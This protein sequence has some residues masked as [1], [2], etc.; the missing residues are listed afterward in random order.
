VHD[1]RAAR[2]PASAGAAPGCGR[3]CG[4]RRGPRWGGAHP[5][6]PLGHA[7]P[8]AR[9]TPTRS[10]RHRCS[11]G[12]PGRSSEAGRRERGFDGAGF[13]RIHR[14]PWP[15]ARSRQG[16]CARRV[17]RLAGGG[18]FPDAMQSIAVAR[19]RIA[20]VP[21]WDFPRA[22]VGAQVFPGNDCPGEAPADRHPPGP[23][24][25][26]VRLPDGVGQAGPR[27]ELPRIRKLAIPRPGP[28]STS[29]PP[30]TRK[31]QAIGKDKAGRWQYRYHPRFR[32]RQEQ[33]KFQKLVD[34]AGRAAEDAQ[35]RRPGHPL[36]R[37]SAGTG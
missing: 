29:R 18:P 4:R 36:A 9:S 17:E 10:G 11:R 27:L 34:F 25:Q 16:I 22:E 31:L 32:E 37:G 13:H 3:R 28:R 35:A 19:R 30:P 1:R 20:M 21:G 26:G 12:H 33:R 15:P 8:D 5:E 7:G 14:S 24:R 2:H 6:S 23:R